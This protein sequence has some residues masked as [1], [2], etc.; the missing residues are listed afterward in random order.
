MIRALAESVDADKY[1]HDTGLSFGEDFGRH[2]LSLITSSPSL[3]PPCGNYKR[4]DNLRETT[5]RIGKTKA[6]ELLR[7]I[8]QQR[9]LFPSGAIDFKQYYFPSDLR[10]ELL[11]LAPDWLFKLTPNGPT[12]MV[13]VSKNGKCLGTHRDKFRS[14]SLFM[15]LQGGEQETRWYRDIEDFEVIDPL[16]IPDHDKIEHVVSAVI[17]P[18]R[19]YVFNHVEWH[20]VHNFAPGSVRVSMGLDFNNV[21]AQELVE[22]VIKHTPKAERQ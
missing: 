1:C 11:A 18:F 21:T 8:N 19:W 9:A 14:A 4:L 3:F 12:P 6:R 2:A 15:L 20:S 10:D 5:R 7:R 16:W 13:Q 17:Q 22:L